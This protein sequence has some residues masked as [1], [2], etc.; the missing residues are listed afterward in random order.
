MTKHSTVEAQKKRKKI[1]THLWSIV[2]AVEHINL[3]K[4]EDAVK[5]EFNCTED[6]FVKA[7]IELMQTE[8]R[9]NVQS[10]VKVWIRQ[11]TDI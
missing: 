11:P 1:Q 2:G 8:S 3:P 10:K 9:I 5:K 6:R 4:L 7:Q